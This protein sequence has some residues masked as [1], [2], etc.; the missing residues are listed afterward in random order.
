MQ[1][2]FAESKKSKLNRMPVLRLFNMLGMVRW[3]EVNGE[4]KQYLRLLHPLS[5]LW[6]A[7]A[8][9]FAIVMQGVPETVIDLKD[10][11]KNETVWF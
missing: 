1:N 5:W 3:K 10:S 4:A 11:F 6:I 8:S 7:A 9:L 2:L